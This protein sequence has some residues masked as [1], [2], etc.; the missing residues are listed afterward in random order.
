ME[1]LRIVSRKEL[2]KKISQDLKSREEKREKEL[3]RPVQTA[4]APRKRPKKT[5]NQKP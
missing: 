2:K 3:L 4:Q 1:A 5:K